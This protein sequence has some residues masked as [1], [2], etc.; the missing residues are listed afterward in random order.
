MCGWTYSH[1]NRRQICSPG[2]H[3]KSSMYVCIIS[4]QLGSPLTYSRIHKKNVR[5][6]GVVS[7]LDEAHEGER[8]GYICVL[9]GVVSISNRSLGRSVDPVVTAISDIVASIVGAAEAKVVS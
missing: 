6:R 1:L 2:D 3:Y 5:R 8:L 9:S 7:I 4:K